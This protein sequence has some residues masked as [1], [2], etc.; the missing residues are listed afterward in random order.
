MGFVIFHQKRRLWVLIG[1]HKN[2]CL[3]RE[4]ILTILRS[5]ITYIISGP[6]QSGVTLNF[7]CSGQSSLTTIDTFTNKSVFLCGH[8]RIR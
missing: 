7:K 2:K 1:P 8:S 5:N 3:N 4:K 6:V